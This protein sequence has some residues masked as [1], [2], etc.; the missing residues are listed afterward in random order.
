M[1]LEHIKSISGVKLYVYMHAVF[2]TSLCRRI[3]VALKV[4]ASSVHRC[5]ITSSKLLFPFNM[6]FAAV[7]PSGFGSF[8]SEAPVKPHSRSTKPAQVA[9][10][11]PELGRRV[12][13]KLHTR[14][15]FIN[16][17]KH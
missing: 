10:K 3:N 1:Y 16:V 14:V 7:C 9:T 12:F 13:R 2:W 5:K 8:G 17:Y 4:A 15:A 11:R 6:F